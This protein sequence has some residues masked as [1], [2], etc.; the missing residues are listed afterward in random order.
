MG[1]V[2]DRKNYF[3]ESIGNNRLGEKVVNFTYDYDVRNAN[4][5]NL[6]YTID[7]PVN[8][9]VPESLTGIICGICSDTNFKPQLHS[10][11]SRA[12]P[13]GGSFL[14]YSARTGYCSFTYQSN[15]FINGYLSHTPLIRKTTIEATPTLTNTPT[16]TPTA[17]PI[18]FPPYKVI[19]IIFTPKD[20]VVPDQ[21]KMES[22]KKWISY[23]QAWYAA[24][25]DNKSFSPV[26]LISYVGKEDANWYL[27]C[28]KEDKNNCNAVEV[29]FNVL[30]E[31][32]A[33]GYPVGYINETKEHL[34]VFFNGYSGDYVALGSDGKSYN[35]MSF[36][37]IDFLSDLFL[38]D[39]FNLNINLYCP[40]ASV[41]NGDAGDCSKFHH[42]GAIA[43]EMGHTF[44]LPEINDQTQPEKKSNYG[45]GKSIM[46]TAV[47]IFPHTGFY[48]NGPNDEKVKMLNSPFMNYQM[49]TIPSPVSLLVTYKKSLSVGWNL[50]SNPVKLPYM[51]SNNP[52]GVSQIYYSLG[53]NCQEIDLINSTNIDGT[54]NWSKYLCQS[55]QSDLPL[56]VGQ[57]YWIKMNN[58]I[59]LMYYGY[60]PSSQPVL[61]LKT[62]WNLVG[63]ALWGHNNSV[64]N[65]LISINQKYNLVY[66]YKADD[67]NNPWK[68]YD[69]N[70]PSFLNSLSTIESGLGYWINMTADGQWTIDNPIYTTQATAVVA[71]QSFGLSAMLSR[72]DIINTPTPTP[73]PKTIILNLISGTDDAYQTADANKKMIITTNDLRLGWTTSRTGLRFVSNN[74]SG[75]KGKTIKSAKL[76]LTSNQNTSSAIKLSIFAQN[77]DSCLTY[78]TVKNNLGLRPITATP[79]SWNISTAWKS[80]T[81]YT[82]PELASVIQQVVGR[83]GYDG[84]TLCIMMQNNGSTNNTERAVTSKENSSRPSATLKIEYY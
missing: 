62:G 35:N 10:T 58:P 82:S 3:N 52:L 23:V 61:T 20:Q 4:F 22:M 51:T 18:P 12:F 24:R 70:R 37:S 57:G 84:K 54:A 79:I 81:Q 53:P 73:T 64:T 14:D 74:L 7:V 65:S 29:Y 56:A 36:L 76:T 41:N 59:H 44:G 33:A 77:S 11:L 80:G 1:A 25:L 83:P 16:P 78:S 19:P 17:T 27:Q 67:I 48:E 32:L 66:G 5:T 75:V 60:L 69:I 49:N 72:P 6:I 55:A 46:N 68:I 31:L 39:P 45:Y 26:E 8:N 38:K 43:H 15:R 50:L 28:Y 2:F 47:N 40:F 21:T 71:P 63:P 13:Q 34:L 9:Q 30:N 42:L